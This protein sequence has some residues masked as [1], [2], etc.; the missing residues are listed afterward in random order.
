MFTQVTN[1]VKI[2][3]AITVISLSAIQASTAYAGGG[4]G[5]DGAEFQRQQKL[6]KELKAAGT[7]YRTRAKIISSVGL[8]IGT[9]VGEASTS[10]VTCIA[11]CFGVDDGYRPGDMTKESWKGFKKMWGMDSKKEK[12]TS[13]RTTRR[14]EAPQRSNQPSIG[15]ARG[16]VAINPDR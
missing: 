15:T 11:R 3:L 10:V 12:R 9:A 6:A 13:N 1:L 2:I 5:G 7:P 14:A 4:G 8:F 16:S